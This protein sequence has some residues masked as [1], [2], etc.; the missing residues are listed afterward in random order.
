MLLQYTNRFT[1]VSLHTSNKVHVPV[2]S[3]PKQMFKTSEQRSF[4]ITMQCRSCVST[5]KWRHCKVM[6]L[7]EQNCSF[8]IRKISMGWYYNWT[9]RNKSFLFDKPTVRLCCT[10]PE[11]SD[12]QIFLR[13]LDSLVGFFRPF[14]QMEIKNASKVQYL[15]VE[16]SSY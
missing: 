3:L 11:L 10:P 6:S 5:L 7:H 14:L 8:L 1:P 12:I 4:N 15:S 9:E 16:K 2:K 13:G